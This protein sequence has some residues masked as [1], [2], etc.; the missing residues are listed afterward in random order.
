MQEARFKQLMLGLP[1]E[2]IHRIRDTA[3]GVPEERYDRVLSELQV[4]L[5]YR[6]NKQKTLFSLM[7]N[8]HCSG[9]GRH[10]LVSLRG[11][12]GEYC[13][14]RCWKD[15]HDGFDSGYDEDEAFRLEPIYIKY[16]HLDDVNLR[17]RAISKYHRDYRNKNSVSG[18]VWPMINKPCYNACI[19]NTEL[20]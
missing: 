4:V 11:Y 9:C 5:R 18:F 7:I 20:P 1:C 17:S 14:K 19:L 10:Y 8:T 3:D 2:L 13:R 6:L 12:C 16:Q 15:F